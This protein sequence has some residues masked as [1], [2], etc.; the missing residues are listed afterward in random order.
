MVRWG[1]Y[2]APR[3]FHRKGSEFMVA[4]VERHL[5]QT[6]MAVALA[7]RAGLFPSACSEQLINFD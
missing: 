5:S 1:H 2:L 4:L 6:R 7:R 3:V